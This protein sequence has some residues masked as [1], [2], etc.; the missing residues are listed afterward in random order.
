MKETPPRAW[1]RL[2]AARQRRRHPG[3]TPTG[4]GKTSP[5]PLA[6]AKSRKHPHGRGEDRP[7][8]IGL[9][10]WPETPPR[11][12]G[13][14]QGVH[15]RLAVGGN[16]PTGVGKT[17][18]PPKPAGSSRKHP[19]GRGEDLNS[20]SE[21]NST[22]ETPPRAWGRRVNRC[23][24]LKLLRN[25]PTGVGKT[26]PAAWS[27]SCRRK[28]PHGRGEDVL[29]ADIYRANPETPPRAWGRRRSFE[30]RAMVAGNTPTG[31]G[32]TIQCSNRRQQYGKHPHGR[33]EDQIPVRGTLRAPETPPRAWGRPAAPDRLDHHPGNTPTGVGKT[34]LVRMPESRR[35]K[36]PHGRGEDRRAAASVASSAETPPR[37][38]GRRLQRGFARCSLGNTPTGVG[39]T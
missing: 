12:W 19:H 2:C 6:K 17:T 38:W 4:V 13:R 15:A 16:T 21:H 7:T 27:A 29:Y 26:W 36:H 37:A 33:G 30:V 20:P 14:P 8:Q 28:H 34:L 9:Y 18:H 24:R 11:A 5:L 31:V 22:M 39:K 35:G 25:T 10:S 32:K 1:G 23:G 3:N